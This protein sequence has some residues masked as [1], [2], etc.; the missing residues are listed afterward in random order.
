MSAVVC[1]HLSF[2]WPDGTPALDGLD[3]AFGAGR[4]GLVGANGSGKSTLLRLVTGELRPTGG[5]VS[6]SGDVGYLPQ[7]IPLAAGR[8]ASDLLGISAIRAAL[9]AVEAGD[10]DAIPTVGDGWDIEERAVAELARFGL[11]TDLDRPVEALSGGEAVL[12]G[13]V[14]LLVRRPAI[15]LLDEPTNNLDRRARGLLQA[16]VAS[17]PGVLLLVSHDRE[18]LEDVD[19]IAELHDGR[20]RMFGGAFRAYAQQLARERETAQRRVRAAET[21]LRREQRQLVEAHTKLD[22]RRR[23]A[24][25]DHADKR[26]PKIVMNQRRTE[27]Q[28]SAGKHRNLHEQRLG[29]ARERLAAAESTVRDDDPVRIDLPDTAVPTGRT[30]LHVGGLVVRGPERIGLLGANGSGKTTL[31][32]G[33]EAEVPTGYLP[34]RLDVLDD[35]ASVLDNVRAAAPGVPPQRVRAGLA[36]FGVQGAAVDLPAGTLSGGERFRVALAR[37]LL[38]DPAPQLLLLDEP[39]NNLDLAGVDRLAEALRSYRGALIVAGH[40]LGFLRRIGITRWWGTDGGLHETAP[41]EMPGPG[42]HLGGMD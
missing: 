28:V 29:D 41:H 32:R 11:P 10:V 16:A 42:G 25:T 39:T 21:T 33:I 22:R 24:A 2:E 7:D 13:L 1:S 36:R 40:D 17:W 34:Q 35:A 9:H 38:A 12:T 30:V 6:T 4:T 31:L 37:V 26:K 5:T 8:T 3:V 18:L 27:A 15:S 23:H 19:E 14:G 20:V